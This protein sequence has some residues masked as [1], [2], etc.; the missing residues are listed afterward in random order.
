[1]FPKTWRTAKDTCRHPEPL[2]RSSPFTDPLSHL[3]LFPVP[4][5]R[6][7]SVSLSC[8]PRRLTWF[9]AFGIYFECGAAGLLVGSRIGKQ[10]PACV[11]INALLN[12]LV[13]LSLP[14]SPPPSLARREKKGIWKD[15]RT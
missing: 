6:L 3:A 15:K 14:L 4:G 7:L 12:S 13:S 9:V 10:A 11:L 8:L 1:M 5:S 2:S